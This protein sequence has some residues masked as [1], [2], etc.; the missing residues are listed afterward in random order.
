MTANP[1]PRLL[2]LDLGTRRTG[3]AVSDDLA[4]FAHTRPAIH[5]RDVQ[6]LV[7]AVQALVQSEDAGEVI[8]GLPLG[9]SGRDT[10]QTKD[11][12]DIIALLRARLAVPVTTWDERF[13]SIQAARSSRGPVPRRS[14]ALDSAAAAI[15]L[16]AVLDSRRSRE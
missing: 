3:V 9:L 7:S 1:A 13:S 12:R 5:H 11:A 2:C 16:Q 14:G 8:V 4:A 10:A 15:V 6:G